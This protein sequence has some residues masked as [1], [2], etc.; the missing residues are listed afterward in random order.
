V[1]EKGGGLAVIAGQNFTPTAY[2]DTPLAELLPIDAAASSDAATSQQSF[3]PVPTDLG[4]ATASFQLGESDAESREI[5]R[6]LP[7]LFWSY[8]VERLKPAAQVLAEHSD[9]TASDGRPLPLIVLHYVGAGKVLFHAIDETYRWRY[10]VGDVFFARYWVQTIRLLG[11]TRLLGQ[12]RSASL[13]A[14][15]DEYRLG[16]PVRL[17]LRYIDER[18]APADDDGVMVLLESRGRQQE[19]VTMHRSATHRGIFEATLPQL[20][21]GEH[22]VLLLAPVLPSGDDPASTPPSDEFRVVAP[23]GE[24]EKLQT[25]S[26]ALRAAAAQTHGRFYHFPQTDSL[27]D[28]LPQ[29]R[30]VPIESLPPLPLWNRWELLCLF[31]FVI[32]GE[33]TIRKVKGML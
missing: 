30:Q 1:T 13:T 4:L 27:A 23:P 29:G 18:L 3:R 10:R 14:D 6:N 16:E 32:T 31:L 21:V 5:W 2:R 22:R 8:D 25:D 7:K 28:D 26:A 15:R 17:R 24:S 9:R 20:G 19:T 12:N 11:R 33:W